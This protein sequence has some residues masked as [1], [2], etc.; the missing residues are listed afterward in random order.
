[1]AYFSVLKPVLKGKAYRRK[2]KFRWKNVP[3]AKYY[4]VYKN[5]KFYKKIFVKKGKLN[6]LIFKLKRKKA[7]KLKI[8]AV[9]TKVADRKSVV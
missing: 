4:K 3:N 2:V 5:K 6:K 8:Y 9:G 1:M 7:I